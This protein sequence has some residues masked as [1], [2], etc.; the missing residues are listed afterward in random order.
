M[1]LY[2][3][4]IP[5]L[6]NNVKVYLAGDIVNNQTTFFGRNKDG[7]VAYTV[8]PGTSLTE[9]E[10]IE[11]FLD[12][13][14]KLWLDFVEAIVNHAQDKNILPHQEY[15]NQGRMEEMAKHM[16]TLRIAFDTLIHNAKL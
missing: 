15:K 7:I 3:E 14:R 10:G 13:P 6:Q 5:Y 12:M 9:K 2:I 8:E 11:P 4:D 16:E 1:K